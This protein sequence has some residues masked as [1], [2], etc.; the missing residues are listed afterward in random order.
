MPGPDFATAAEVAAL[1]PGKLPLSLQRGHLVFSSPATLA[2][3]A[4]GARGVGVKKASLAIPGSVMLLI[5]P[6]CCGRNTA[7]LGGTDRDLEARTHYLLLDGTDIVTGRYLK[8]VPDAVKELCA[9]LASPPSVVVLCT[10]C[11]DALLATDVDR[12][13]RESSQA[14]G[15]PVIA[16]TMYAL[17]R[18]SRRPPMEEVRVSLYSLLEKAPR[19]P[20]SC[21]I[22]GYFSPLQNGCELYGILVQAGIKRT[23][24]LSRAQSMDDYRAMAT[25]AFNLVLDPEAGLAARDLASRLGM[26]WAQLSRSFQTDKIANQYRLLG[27][28]LGRRTDDSRWRE[29]AGRR[30]EAFAA[31]W[32][33]LA[34]AVGEVLCARPFDLALALL[35]MGL[36][37]PEIFAVPGRGDRALVA[38]IAALSPDTRIYSSLSPTML[39]YGQGGQGEGCRADLALGQDARFYHPRLPGTDWCPPRQP[40]GYA[41]L[42]ALLDEMEAALREAGQ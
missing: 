19:D 37:V 34:C 5:A 1:E 23:R 32:R 16:T 29:E 31:R 7:A 39:F 4:P 2:F 17:T 26:P 18:E 10:T 8:R 41:G 38:R 28:V 21:N 25:S 30:V 9:F 36:R 35:R 13:C 22:L 40:F 42:C 14:A 15:V 24:E 3:N 11:V 6:A 20:A 12:L 27:E 33:G